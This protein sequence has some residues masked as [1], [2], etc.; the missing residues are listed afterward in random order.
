M[1]VQTGKSTASVAAPAPAPVPRAVAWERLQF[2]SSEL[3]L[4]LDM[5]TDGVSLRPGVASPELIAVFMNYLEEVDG[6]RNAGELQ[7][8]GPVPELAWQE[9][10]GALERLRRIVPIMEQ[11]L[12]SDRNRLSQERNRLVGAMEW[13]AASKLTR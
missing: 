10:R 8:T 4:M 13:N 5:L 11:Q 2:I 7:E 3:K 12:V 6:L 9:Y 1:K